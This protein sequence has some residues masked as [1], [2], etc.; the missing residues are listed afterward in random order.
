MVHTKTYTFTYF[1]EQY[2][3]L[4]TM[5]PR[6]SGVGLWRRTHAKK[7]STTTTTTTGVYVLNCLWDFNC[8][9]DGY[10]SSGHPCTS[11]LLYLLATRPPTPA[12]L[13]PRAP[14]P[15]LSSALRMRCG[16]VRRSFSSTATLTA[17]CKWPKSRRRCSWLRPWK[18]NWKIS[19]KVLHI[20]L[21]R[22][23]LRF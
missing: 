19:R 15:Y 16:L 4:F 8:C 7:S 22:L 17:T 18:R 23:R 14:T 9:I 3:V 11:P 13:L 6:N 1:Y 21:Y 12:H 20:V 2:L 5:V 10:G